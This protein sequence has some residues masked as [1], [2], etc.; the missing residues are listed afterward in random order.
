LDYDFGCIYACANPIFLKE[1][2][3]IYYGGSDWLHTGWRNGCLALATLR[4]DGFAGYEQ[5]NTNELGRIRTNALDYKGQAVKV[6]AD[7]SKNGWIKAS[8]IDNAHSVISSVQI[9]KTSTDTNLFDRQVIDEDT[10]RIEFELNAAK[11]YSFA[12]SSE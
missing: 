8:L 3:R 10:V 4:P 5:N 7:I 11:L 9:S 12:F 2:I 1:E 6:S